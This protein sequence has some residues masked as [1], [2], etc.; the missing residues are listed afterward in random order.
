MAVPTLQSVPTA[1]S[2]LLPAVKLLIFT[3]LTLCS[4]LTFSAGHQLDTLFFGLLLFTGLENFCLFKHCQHILFPQCLSDSC[5]GF[6]L[7]DHYF[8][9]LPSFFFF[10]LILLRQSLCI[11]DC[12]GTHSVDQTGLGLT[13][14]RLPVLPE[15]WDYRR[16]P[17]PAVSFLCY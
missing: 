1:D 12:P 11:P 16:A 4:P 13:E 17:P 8:R 14:T 3:V 6:P 7:E 10:V 2:R 5:V 15:C 9:G